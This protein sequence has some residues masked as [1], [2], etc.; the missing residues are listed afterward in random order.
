MTALKDACNFLGIK[1]IPKID[2]LYPEIN[3]VISISPRPLLN[4]HLSYLYSDN[5]IILS[6]PQENSITN[7]DSTCILKVKIC[8]VWLF[9]GMA[10]H[11]N[12]STDKYP[13]EQSLF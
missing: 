7:K 3:S 1:Y 6:E 5:D 9:L 4:L 13:S 11:T 12:N 2:R 10:I 8:T